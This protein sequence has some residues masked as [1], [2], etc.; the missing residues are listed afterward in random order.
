ME[1]MPAEF[2]LDR[3][4]CVVRSRAWGNLTEDDLA[5][6][7]QAMRELFESGT[8][9][10]TWAQVCDFSSITSVAELT[11]EGVRR[12]AKSNPWPLEALRVIVAPNDEMYGLGRMYQ[13]MAV[14]DSEH[15]LVVRSAAEA[16][17]W[18]TERGHA[19]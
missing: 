19:P 12:L 17:E 10:A 8:L 5:R 11:T 4:G 13:A 14:G 9:D 2:E 6:H 16:S 1:R 15:F 18:M 7:V 3:E